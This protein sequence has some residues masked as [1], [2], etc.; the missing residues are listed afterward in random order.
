MKKAKS[1]SGLINTKTSLPQLAPKEQCRENLEPKA[2]PTKTKPV[3]AKPELEETTKA[4][5]SNVTANQ[6]YGQAF[7]QSPEDKE[8]S[9]ISSSSH[10]EPTAENF[11]NLSTSHISALSSNGVEKQVKIEDLCGRKTKVRFEIDSVLPTHSEKSDLS[12]TQSAM[13]N[14]E[15]ELQKENCHP[16]V[17]LFLQFYGA[18]Q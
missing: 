11:V 5:S 9:R 6:K 17:R 13:E 7:K 12:E 18:F 1:A 10:A 16:E 2:K 8:S 4:K 3:I 14:S 15:R